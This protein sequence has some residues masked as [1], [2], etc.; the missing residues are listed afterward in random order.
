MQAL[1]KDQFIRA[2]Q[3]AHENK[4]TYENMSYENLRENISVT[5]PTHGDFLV[6]AG[7]H[8]SGKSGCRK[9]FGE[10]V[11]KRQTKPFAIFL[12]EAE[13]VHGVT[14]SYDSSTYKNNKSEISILCQEHGW[15]QQIARSHINGH[16]CFGCFRDKLK[17]DTEYFKKKSIEVHGDKYDYSNSIYVSSS[18]KL[19]ITCQEHGVFKQSPSCHY[20][21]QGCELCAAGGF[22]GNLE[23]Y[24]YVLKS[25]NL[26]KVGITNREVGKRLIDINSS[27]GGNFKVVK[28]F[29]FEKGEDAH[30]LEKHILSKLRGSYIQPKEK[31]EGYTECFFDIEDGYLDSLIYD[32]IMQ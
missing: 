11:S 13:L 32:W 29:Y 23:G 19:D 30:S 4:Y 1:T 3:K 26:T 31:F 20:K 15:F 17:K 22:K 18:E 2:A 16:G 10:D 8:K 25:S 5:C 6:K 9:C 7:N 12:K 27:K 28:S 14:Y 21:G 24:L